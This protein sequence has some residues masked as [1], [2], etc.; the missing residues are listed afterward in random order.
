MNVIDELILDVEALKM[1]IKNTKDKEFFS[2]VTHYVDEFSVKLK[3]GKITRQEIVLLGKKIEDFFVRWRPDPEPSSGFPYIPPPEASSNDDTAASIFRLS[4][5]LGSIDDIKFSKLITV[6]SV[7]DLAKKDKIENCIFIG[8]GRSKLWA[9]VQVFIQDEM[10]VKTI[11]YESESRAG[12]SIVPILEDML[13]KATF[14]ILILTAE[15]ETKDGKMRARQNVIHEAGLFQG[16]LGFEKA[17]LLLQNGSENFTN[18][19]G[20]QYIGF[21]DENIEQTFYELQRVLKRESIITS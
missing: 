5:Q 17:I 3:G 2:P 7:D 20:L 19:D 11:S 9:R 8:H 1:S 14:A 4:Q 15:D 13:D 18:V 21:S 12:K 10:K 16:R 6:K